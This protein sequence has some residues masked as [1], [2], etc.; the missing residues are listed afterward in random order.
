MRSRGG[1][2]AFNVLN[3]DGTAIPYA[4]VVDRAR[5]HGVSLRGGCFCN[6]GAAEAAFDFPYAASA[7]CLSAAATDGFS[8]D[9]FSRCLGAGVPV[10]A[11]RLSVGV[12][13]NTQD[14]DRAIDL[15]VSL[16]TSD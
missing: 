2:V 3:P 9:K 11:V 8:I 14:I 16:S 4:K 10:G 12:P 7:R 15:I 6:P 5:E 1:A 13:T